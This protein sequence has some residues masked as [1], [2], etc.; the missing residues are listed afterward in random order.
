M[1]RLSRILVYSI[2]GVVVPSFALVVADDKQSFG[3]QPFDALG[4]LLALLI[5]QY[6]AVRLTFLSMLP[7][8]K[9]IP[10]A[11]HVFFYLWCGIAPLIQLLTNQIPWGLQPFSF[12][13]QTAM[14]C[15][16]LAILSFE[17]GYIVS[18]RRQ[19]FKMART[20]TV[21]SGKGL[22]IAIV[23]SCFSALYFGPLSTSMI[24]LLSN[25]AEILAG[26][27]SNDITRSSRLFGETLMRMPILI[28]VI[29]TIWYLRTKANR[30]GLAYLG[31]AIQLPLFLLVNFPLAVSRTW[32]GAIVMSIISTIVVTGA[33][34]RR[35]LL[36]VSILIGVMTVYPLLHYAR[37]EALNLSSGI[38]QSIT[39]TYTEGSFDVF[40]MTLALFVAT[41]QGSSLISFGYQSLGAVFFWV[42]RA[43]WEGKP[44]GSGTIIADELHFSFNNVSAPLWVEGYMNFGWIGVLMFPFALGVFSKWIERRTGQTGD[45]SQFGL[46]Q[47]FIGGTIFIVLRGDLITASVQ[48]L[49]FLLLIGIFRI[50][51][52]RLNVRTASAPS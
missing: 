48:T 34:R 2:M 50:A 47:V 10:I 30:R 33:Q 36:V 17:I 40:A 42:P 37:S 8:F 7:Q 49:P 32:F 43:I 15:M 14:F 9:V 3:L 39:D 11:A 23:L 27:T 18:I 44:L 31:L 38:T 29:G 12:E 28:T 6:S 20:K 19:N 26:Y 22:G 46:I 45:P 41:S 51:V 13:V 5:I 21:I 24:D 16:V 52:R 35:P 25:R 4:V 1:S